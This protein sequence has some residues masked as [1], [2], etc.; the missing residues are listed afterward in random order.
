MIQIQRLQ[1]DVRVTRSGRR[2][3]NRFKAS[4]TGLAILEHTDHNI[5]V[6]VW[7]DFQRAFCVWITTSSENL[8]AFNILRIV[9]V[10]EDNFNLSCL[11]QRLASLA[12]L[13]EY[14]Q[15]KVVRMGYDGR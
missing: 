11:L 15:A 9:F 1:D 10:A 8:F 14:W 13:L 7:L 2:G 12:L 3:K 4:F 5:V 6:R